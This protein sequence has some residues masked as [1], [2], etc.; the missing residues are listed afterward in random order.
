MDA[1][2]LGRGL[3]LTP[4]GT[5]QKVLKKQTASTVTASHKM[6]TLQALSRSLNAGTAKKGFLGQGFWVT[7]GSLSP[8]NDR[9]MGPRP[10]ARCRRLCPMLQEPAAPEMSYRCSLVLACTEIM[11]VVMGLR[12][13]NS[14]LAFA[15]SSRQ[16]SP[17][18]AKG[19]QVALAM[20]WQPIMLKTASTM[21]TRCLWSLWRTTTT[22]KLPNASTLESHE[23]QVDRLKLKKET[24][25]LCHVQNRISQNTSMCAM[26]R[27][28]F[29]KVD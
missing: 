21:F 8:K 9:V 29:V 6:L 1:E 15:M 11:A 20:T 25:C 16:V 28:R 7:S 22:L 26:I 19:S 4:L 5:P 12:H 10:F 2:G 18:W 23:Q 27:R 17:M 13:A 3:L 24:L 14:A